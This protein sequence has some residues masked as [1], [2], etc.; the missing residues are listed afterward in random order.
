MQVRTPIAALTL[1]LLATFAGQAMAQNSAG[2]KTREQVQNELKEAIRTGNMPAND[3]SGRMLNE[4]NPSAYPPKPVVPC[5]TREQVRAELEEAKRTSNMVAPGESGCLLN[6]LNPSAYPPKPVMPCKTR[7]QV[8]L[9]WKRPNERAI[10]L[11]TVK[12]AVCSKTCTLV[13]ILKSKAQMTRRKTGSAR[14]RSCFLPPPDSGFFDE[15]CFELHRS[16]AFDFAVDVVITVDQ[17]DV[18]DL[19]ADLD[20]RR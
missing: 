15:F 6:E 10:C 7:E 4:V 3:E 17:T 2:P 18:L 1:M 19:G 11:P 16:K 5:K 12:R 9:S 8:R 13:S 14:S 20:H